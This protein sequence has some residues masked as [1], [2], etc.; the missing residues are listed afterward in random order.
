MRMREGA[1]WWQG[2][3]RTDAQIRRRLL[4]ETLLAKLRRRA[5]ST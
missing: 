4:K 5:P 1:W 3:E 2:E